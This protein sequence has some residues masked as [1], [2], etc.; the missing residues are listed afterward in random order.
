[1]FTDQM[2]IGW[3]LGDTLDSWKLTIPS[4]A[5]PEVFETCWNS[6][7]T[8]EA[9]IDKIIG[10]GF[11]LIRIPVTW[12]Q[13]LGEAPE[14]KI[15]ADW[16]A[17]V[18]E[19]VDYAY[20]KG[21]YVILNMHHEEWK[22]YYEYEKECCE[23]VAAVWKQ[24]AREFGSY[25]EH[26]I[27]EGVNEPRK[28][29]TEW[30]WNG[31]DEE[32][33]NVVNSM[34]KSFVQAVRATGTDFIQNKTRKLMVSGYAANCTEPALSH[35]ILPDDQNLIVSVHAY[36]PWDFCLNMQGRTTWNHDTQVIDRVL[37]D[38]QKY[39]LSKG[40]PVIIGEF[41]A[42]NRE[43]ET[44]RAE[45]A[46]YYIR[47]AHKIGVP[48]VWWDN[49]KFQGDCE[50]FGLIDRESLEWTYPLVLEGLMKGLE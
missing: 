8:T 40:V 10:A 42:M 36:E 37:G 19:V 38:I 30:E 49:S 7:V 43:N 12:Q 11:N 44:E 23:K 1:M 13:H 26:L 21:V 33:W 17:R 46:E 20:K 9:V 5:A 32:G 16:M 24:I 29:G 15:R 14:Y 28:I 41:G 39:F 34:A 50:K 22:T 47:E 45:W 27:F 31:G 3:N 35:I 4:D 48:C 2:R 25:D 6:P 18:R